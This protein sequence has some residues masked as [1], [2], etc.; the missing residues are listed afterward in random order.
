MPKLKKSEKYRMSFRKFLKNIITVCCAAVL[1]AAV[2]VFAINGY[3]IHK[4]KVRVLDVDEASQLNDVDCIL[5][6]GASVKPDK[7]PSNMLYDRIMTGVSLY[8]A[9]AA[10]KII[11]S[12]DHGRTDY[13]EV[14][15]MKE[16]AISSGVP[17]EDIFMDHAGFSTYESLYRAK[18][19]FG[20]D[21]II[22]V[23]QKYHLYRALYIAEALGMEAYGVPADLRS[24]S[25]QYKREIRE[26]LARNKDFILAITKPVPTTMSDSI[27][28]DG[29]GDVTND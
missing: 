9:G 29:S 3:V 22:I 12:G 13:N 2:Y 25:G 28:L 23:S 26:I 8:E 5:V 1:V 27:S 14:G 24:Y 15:T 21:K 16:Y 4:T 10:P 11:M 19:M 20:A 17:S 7:T 18:E 6:L